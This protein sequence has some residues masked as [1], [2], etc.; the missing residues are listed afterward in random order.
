[1]KCKNEIL[2]MDKA[3]RMSEQFRKV[4][5][6]KRRGS[7]RVPSILGRRDEYKHSNAT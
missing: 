3:G 1:M 2:S 4:K 5:G 7:A 6:N